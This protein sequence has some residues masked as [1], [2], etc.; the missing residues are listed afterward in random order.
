MIDIVGRMSFDAYNGFAVDVDKDGTQEIG[1][2]LDMT[3]MIFKFNG[4]K[5]QWGFD[6]FYLKL[7]DFE[8]TEGRY[9]G[10]MMYDINSDEIEELL[11]MTDKLFNNYHD[12]KTFTQIYKPTDLVDVKEP[13]VKTNTYKLYQNYP[14]PFNTST[15]IEYRI[16]KTEFV[17]LIVYD[18]LGREVATLV[19]EQQPPGNYEIQFNGINLNSGIYFIRIETDKYTNTVKALLIK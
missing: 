12:K 11:I 8:K 19:N 9:W 15:N 18:V 17:S 4:S 6:L 13:K 3:F 10:A 2:C 14:N 5:D 7:N 16:Q 1:L